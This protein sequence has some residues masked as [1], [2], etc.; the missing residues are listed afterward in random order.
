MSQGNYRVRDMP[1]WIKQSPLKNFHH[2][3]KR[4]PSRHPVRMALSL[5]SL[6]CVGPLSKRTRLVHT[7]TLC[8]FPRRLLIKELNALLHIVD[9]RDELTNWHPI[10]LLNVSYKIF[11]N[12]L[13]QRLQLLLYEV[14][15]NDQYVFL[16]LRYIL[17][18]MFLSMQHETSYHC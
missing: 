2:H 9:A 7:F 10:I 16:P 15:N 17:D 11:V 3:W 4:W 14:I 1:H 5:N 18:N 6:R 13:Q 12:A 8:K